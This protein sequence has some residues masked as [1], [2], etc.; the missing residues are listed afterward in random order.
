[1]RIHLSSSQRI[2]LICLASAA[3]FW[4]LAKLSDSYA[5]DMP[6]SIEFENLP[7]GL[8]IDSENQVQIPARIRAEGYRLVIFNWL[9]RPHI[10]MDARRAFKRDKTMYCWSPA[11]DKKAIADLAYHYEVLSLYEDSLIYP[12]VETD[13]EHLPIRLPKPIEFAEGYDSVGGLQLSPDSVWV[14][15][16]DAILDTLKAIQTAPYRLRNV[17]RDIAATLAVVNPDPARVRMDVQTVKLSL[18]VSRFAA[19][20]FSLPVANDSLGPG[21]KIKFFPARV[22]LH[23]SLPLGDYGKLRAA[24]FKVVADTADLS[25]ATPYLPLKLIAAPPGVR[26]VHITPEQVEYLIVEE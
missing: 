18:K 24:D 23:F 16:P 26:N 20:D 9:K 19:G 21:K 6:L 14:T 11:W 3:L 7:R 2:F 25:K 4:F 8:Y 5:V 17:R 10:A 1:M 13:R 15:A 22:K 12:I